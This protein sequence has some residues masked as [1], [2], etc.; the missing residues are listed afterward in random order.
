VPGTV[1]PAVVSWD[2]ADSLSP[3]APLQL[4]TID[5]DHPLYATRRALRTELRTATDGADTT[6]LV[7][8]RPAEVLPAA[9]GHAVVLLDTASPEAE[10]PR[11]VRLALGLA[12]PETPDEERVVAYFAPVADALVDADIDLER[13]VRLSRFTT[14]SAEDGTRDLER[15]AEAAEAAVPDAGIVL[16]EVREHPSPAIAR[17]VRL[18]LTD[19]PAF[20]TEDG[21]LARDADGLP[22]QTGTRDVRVRV[23]LPE[24]TAP[25]R[26]VLFGHGTGGDYTDSTFDE[27]L[28]AAGIAKV[29]LR[30]DGWTGDDFLG[31]ALGFTKILHGSERS[32]AGL[33]QALSAAPAVL[34]AL[35]G[36]LGEALAAD[37]LGDAPNPLAGVR[38]DLDR[39]AWIGGSLGGTL[40]PVVVANDPRMDLAVFNVPG[41]GWSHL[42]P[43]SAIF[44][45]GLR[46]I[47][48]ATYGQELDLMLGMVQSQTC[49]DPVDGAVWADAAV[50]DGA[51]AL[52]QLSIGDGVV[53]NHSSELLGQGLGAV[54]LGPTLAPIH[55][56]DVVD[57]PVQGGAGLSQ[58]RV[59][60]DGDF[61]VH[62]FAAR[63][64]PAGRA[65]LGQVTTF[66]LSGWEDGVPTLAHPEGCA[67]TPDGTCDFSDMP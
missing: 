30:F 53:P 27:E 25:Y 41:A 1:D 17:I 57:E 12:S 24:T 21:A 28:A 29:G 61:Q 11:R 59:R 32:T 36:P 5:P 51:H 58:F 46:G 67:V 3:S 9:T 37:T 64:T 66:L 4:V 16:D 42:I 44:D 48:G 2:P 15:L 49:W 60:D 10:A 63:D 56:L 62:G 38:P 26:V 54:H 47:I 52:I 55:G 20:R 22:L 34:T 50:D 19:M 7:L 13:V 40:G 8:G 18:R 43:Y 23:V 6:T 14:R 35:E 33:V 65:A 45:M 31:M 39:P